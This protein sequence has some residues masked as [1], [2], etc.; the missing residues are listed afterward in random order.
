MGRYDL[1]WIIILFFI[2]LND[3]KVEKL[4]ELSWKA[5]LV[6]GPD[7]ENW[8]LEPSRSIL[9]NKMEFWGVL[10]SKICVHTLDGVIHSKT[11]LMVQAMPQSELICESYAPHMLTYLVDHHDTIGCHI[12]PPL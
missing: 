11:F 10:V 8:G 12:I 4:E 2:Y 5:I 3:F 6:L 1:D 7:L 9:R